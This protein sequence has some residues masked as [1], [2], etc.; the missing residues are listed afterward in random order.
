M[1]FVS[2]KLGW[3]ERWRVENLEFVCEYQGAKMENGNYNIDYCKVLLGYKSGNKIPVFWR[4]R[5]LFHQ[6]NC[7]SLIWEYFQENG[8]I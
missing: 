5:L 3:N 4:E 1:N 6:E 2:S 8:R 7:L